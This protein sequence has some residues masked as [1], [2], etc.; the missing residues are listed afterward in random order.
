MRICA[1]CALVKKEY[2]F[3]LLKNVEEYI[4]EIVST[5]I[6]RACQRLKIIAAKTKGIVVKVNPNPTII[7]FD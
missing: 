6:C 5:L 1:H 4:P 3:R 2:E 7:T